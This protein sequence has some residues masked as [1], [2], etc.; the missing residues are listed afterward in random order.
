MKLF[1]LPVLCWTLATSLTFAQKQLP[2]SMKPYMVYQ[3]GKI[4]HILDLA[5][6]D[7]TQKTEAMVNPRSFD[8]VLDSTTTYAN[9]A[10]LDSIPSVHSR[11]SYPQENVEVIVDFTFDV[12]HWSLL[13]RTTIISN[14]FGVNTDIIAQLYDESIQNYVPESRLQVFPHG[15]SADLV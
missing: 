5:G 15:Q 10:P 4:Q 8:P 9:Y 11:Y 7:Q 12:D 1:L 13:S 3:E 6:F 2:T 14:E